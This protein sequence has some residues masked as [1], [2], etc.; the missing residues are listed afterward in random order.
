MTEF[1]TLRD[2]WP[3]PAGVRT[4]DNQRECT[5]HNE[6]TSPGKGNTGVNQGC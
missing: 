6:F 5:E 3:G 4:D 1:G 2:Y